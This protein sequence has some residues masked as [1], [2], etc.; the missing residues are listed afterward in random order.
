MAN[1][2]DSKSAVARLVGSTPTSGTK[3]VVPPWSRY[4]ISVDPIG[5]KLSYTAVCFAL[6]VLRAGF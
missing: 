4:L 5:S 1:A 3:L 2:A 6:C